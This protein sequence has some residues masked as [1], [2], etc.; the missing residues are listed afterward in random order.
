MY[1]SLCAPGCFCAWGVCARECVPPPSVLPV[2][3][4]YTAQHCPPS[5]HAVLSGFALSCSPL[6]RH[7][8][9]TLTTVLP[10][11][12]FL[13]F[14]R[15]ILLRKEIMKTCLLKNKQT[16]N[17]NQTQMFS[18]C[19]RTS[20]GSHSVL[21]W[22]LKKAQS[23]SPW[24]GGRT[25]SALVR[26]HRFIRAWH[27]AP[28]CLPLYS[29]QVSHCPR[30]KEDSRCAQNPKLRQALTPRECPTHLAQ[31][32]ETAALCTVCKCSLDGSF[33]SLQ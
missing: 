3:F 20:R 24:R 23:S 4:Q 16:N 7:W 8:S 6:S 18:L 15:L 29:L 11:F 19:C 28:G 25:L 13:C 1:G 22:S 17:K 9:L 14:L 10:Q 27:K 5:P 26:S 30:G 21:P 31:G 33:H 12:L 2:G 32:G